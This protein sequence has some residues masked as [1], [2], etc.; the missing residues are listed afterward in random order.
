MNETETHRG[1][2]QLRWLLFCALLLETAYAVLNISTMPVYLQSNR[3]LGAA[4]VGLVLVSYLLSEAILKAPL[5][6][7]SDRVGHRL[8][9]MLGGF[10]SACSALLTLLL[11]KGGGMAE[12]G[13]LML[14]RA[15]DGCGA[16]MI[17]P[18]MFALVADLSA[19]GKHQQS[20]SKLNSIYLL[21]I[22]IALP[23]GGFAN[24]QFGGMLANS[25]GSRSP[26]IFLAIL[27]FVLSVVAAAVFLPRKSAHHEEPEASL[28]MK[29]IIAAMRTIPEYLVL[30]LITFAAIG[31]PLAIVKIFAEDQFGMSES[32][33]G[34]VA[35]PCA[36]SLAVLSLPMA[37]I[38]EK[39]G[40]ARAV[41]FGLASCLLGMLAIS[42]GMVVPGLRHPM[43]FGIGA[44]PI[45]IG[46]L[47]TLPAWYSYVGNLAPTNRGTLLGAVMMAQGIGAMLTTPIGGYLYESLRPL[48]NTL[49]YGDGFARYSPFGASAACLA[50]GWVFSLKVLRPVAPYSNR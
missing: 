22:A 33:F 48:G 29:G 41:H 2:H 13:G 12:V 43:L 7:L 10:I 11:P 8:F 18:A 19:P 40:E 1:P 28:Q 46:F 50:L 27:F 37:K 4:T 14:L 25:A 3:G 6:A 20:N 34:L 38:G 31:F 45:G 36:L 26:G 17:W 23:L 9:I 47:L 15:V 42:S 5:G 16:A 24:D 35:L 49:G 39:M 30:A 32:S 44:I 21:G